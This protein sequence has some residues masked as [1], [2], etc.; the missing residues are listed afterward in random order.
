MMLIVDN[1][2]VRESDQMA[3]VRCAWDGGEADFPLVC[4]DVI[5]VKCVKQ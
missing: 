5:H 3:M 2:P 1:L 4:L